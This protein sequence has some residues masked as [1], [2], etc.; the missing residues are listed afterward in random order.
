MTETVNTLSDA[1]VRELR[2]TVAWVR[3]QRGKAA[4][5]DGL[6][7]AEARRDTSPV[8]NRSGS[9]IEEFGLVMLGE[10]EDDLVSRQALLPTVPWPASVGIACA[11]IPDEAPG[12]VW[13]AKGILYPV[14]LEDGFAPAG[15]L[16][17]GMFPFMAVCSI[18][19]FEA[20]RHVGDPVLIVHRKTDDTPNVWAEII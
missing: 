5:G 17:D 2:E 6:G 13:T 9:T 11:E 16:T 1:A 3:E 8:V 10:Y 14:R 20:V 18:T 7:P 19:A 15:G 12:R 4:R